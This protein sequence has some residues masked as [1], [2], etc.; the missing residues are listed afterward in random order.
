MA[1]GFQDMIESCEIFA[2][3][4][5]EGSYSVFAA[6]HDIL[7]VNLDP[8]LFTEEERASLLELGWHANRPEEDGMY[9]DETDSGAVYDWEC[10]HSYRYA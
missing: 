8:N 10:F 3:H 9:D 1:S 6:D 7:W 5:G 2:R 4:D